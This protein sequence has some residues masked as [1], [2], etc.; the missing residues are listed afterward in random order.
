MNMANP[1]MGSIQVSDESVSIEQ[2]CHEQSC[3]EDSKCVSELFC[4]TLVYKRSS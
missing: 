4:L 1:V 2:E 3:S